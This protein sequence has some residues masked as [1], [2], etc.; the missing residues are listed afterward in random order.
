MYLYQPPPCRVTQEPSLELFFL[1]S[2]LYINVCIG[3]GLACRAC[4]GRVVA[5]R[6][7]QLPL[8]PRKTAKN[9]RQRRHWCVPPDRNV[10]GSRRRPPPVKLQSRS[11]PLTENID[12]VLDVFWRK[13]R[14]RHMGT[15]W[16]NK[17]G[18]T[19][20]YE[21]IPLCTNTAFSG[22]VAVLTMFSAIQSCLHG[23]GGENELHWSILIDL[24]YGDGTVRRLGSSQVKEASRSMISFQAVRTAMAQ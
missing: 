4:S 2:Q 24:S 18:A 11:S 19:R 22:N 7:K 6:E 1:V 23:E 20:S 21:N 8:L 14:G 12:V 5:R 3:Y 15:G 10:M 16:E 13:L 9:S 17:P